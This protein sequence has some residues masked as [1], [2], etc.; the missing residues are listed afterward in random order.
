MLRDSSYDYWAIHRSGDFFAASTYSE[1]HPDK[2][3]L[4]VDIRIA[5]TAEAIA[6]CARLYRAL[7]ADSHCVIELAVAYRGL[8]DRILSAPDNLTWDFW[9]EV[10]TTEHDV[11]ASVSFRL[12]S[13]ESDLISLVKKLCAPLFVLFDF[14][15]V[16]DARYGRVVSDFLAGKF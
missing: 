8:N 15:V 6:H 4:R 1:G 10:K 9:D 13:W 16:G 5:R 2:R 11:S 14:T 12:S 7:G 3:H